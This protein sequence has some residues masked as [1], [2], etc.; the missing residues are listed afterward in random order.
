MAEQ[1]SGAELPLEEP[2]LWVEQVSKR[3]WPAGRPALFLDRDGTVIRDTGYPDDPG[4]VTLRD[5]M[6][7]AI[8]AAN[9][10]RIPVVVVT[11]QSGIGRGYF[12]WPVFAAVNRRVLELL[13]EKGCSVDLVI[14]C[15]YHE[16]GRPPYAADAHPMRKPA[17]GMF[18]RAA[19]LLGLDLARSVVVGDKQ[20]DME[21]GRRAGLAG[22]WLV[23]GA[24]HATPDFPILTLTEKRERQELLSAIVAMSAHQGKA[25]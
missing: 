25:T 8:R 7:P 14:A 20:D 16:A 19:E 6:L 2:G 21:A 4:L 18:L 10:T 15:A 3:D 1:G 9:R 22:G 12:G 17:P 11:N 5:D 24:P 13:A 23:E